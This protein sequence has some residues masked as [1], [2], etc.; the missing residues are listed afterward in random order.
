MSVYSELELEKLQIISN[1]CHIVGDY[2][3]Q[4]I[5]RDKMQGVDNDS[6]DR[7]LDVIK[8]DFDN[9]NGVLEEFKAL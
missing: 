3:D 6:K 2:V 1:L 4:V 8:Y 7:V 5:K 9:I